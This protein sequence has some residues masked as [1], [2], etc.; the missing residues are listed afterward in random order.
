[1]KAPYENPTM[2]LNTA[3]YNL[4]AAPPSLADSLLNAFAASTDRSAKGLDV[5]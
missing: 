2:K 3:I 5:V 1:M 4:L